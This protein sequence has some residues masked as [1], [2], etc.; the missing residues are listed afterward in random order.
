MS[1][2]NKKYVSVA[3]VLL[4]ATVGVLFLFLKVN[5]T[6]STL[7]VKT[8]TEY[9]TDMVTLCKD[10]PYR[11]T[12]YEEEVPKLVEFI[13][14]DKIFEVVRAIRKQDPEYLYC[15]VLAHELGR[16]EVSLDPDNWLDVI[17]K[18]PT[19]GLCSNGFAHGAIVTRFNDEDL[20]PTQFTEAQ[21]SLAIACEER[22]GF[23]PTDLTKAICYHGIGHVLIHMTLAKVDESLKACEVIAQKSDG[24]DYRQV[25]TEGVYMQLFQPLEPED[26]ALVDMLP[27][28]PSKETLATFCTS[29][30]Q[31]DAQY[32]ACWREGWPFFGEDIYSSGGVT[33]Y[34]SVLSA[35]QDRDACYIS[36]FTING[37]HNLG[38]PEKMAATCNGLS[39]VHKGTCFARGANAFPEE[40]PELIQNAINMCSRANSEGAQ[41]EC[42]GFLAS[43]AAFNFHKGSP[44]YEELCSSLPPASE[45]V[46]RSN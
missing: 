39:E 34:C 22:A 45:K 30:A 2:R 35:S 32:G 23:T 9:A 4:V 43:V 38:N 42:Y 37:R 14:T 27:L 20:T 25:C 19:D 44:A 11:P 28:K 41:N 17:A 13:P 10:D 1:S 5:K 31:T 21:K 6:E 29:N 12:C 33:E 24:R 18:G 40:S 16:Y 26:Y 36:A 8:I 7:A 15:H 3:L 46:C